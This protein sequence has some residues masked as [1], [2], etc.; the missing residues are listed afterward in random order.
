VAKPVLILPKVEQEGVLL[1]MSIMAGE[2][3]KMV[4]GCGEGGKDGGLVHVVF[5]FAPN[6]VGN[7][8]GVIRHKGVK[9][10]KECWVPQANGH[11]VGGSG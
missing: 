9:V 4:V 10:R 1:I 2:G 3:T 11:G 7:S 5:R 6:K 8:D